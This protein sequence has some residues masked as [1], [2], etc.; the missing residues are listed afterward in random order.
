MAH[1][2]ES[3]KREEK[4]VWAVRRPPW[5]G[6]RHM[7]SMRHKARF[8]AGAMIPVFLG[9]SQTAHAAE[10]AESLA[11]AD[12]ATVDVGA[13]EADAGEEIIVTGE[14]QEPLSSALLSPSQRLVQTGW[15]NQT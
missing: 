13:A 14:K 15:R 4:T 10:A 6:E 8:L 2:L 9:L 1:R 11:T 7:V 12:A 5:H 3:K